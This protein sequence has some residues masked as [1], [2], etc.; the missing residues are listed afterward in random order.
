MVIVALYFVVDVSDMLQERFSS[1]PLATVVESIIFP[2]Y[3][4]PYPAITIC[5]YNRI[6]WKKVDA[7]KDKF[8]PNANSEINEI[9]VNLIKAFA[10]IEFGSFDEFIDL[11]NKTLKDLEHL[12]LT[13]VFESVTK[14][15]IA[16][17]TT[18]ALHTTSSHRL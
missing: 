12:N 13:A 15:Y 3:E 11:K 5:N 6:N 2:V 9:F 10:N 14:L 4:I 18:L 17:F 8:I 16:R 7:A 1:K